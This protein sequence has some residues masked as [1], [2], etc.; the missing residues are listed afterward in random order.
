VI[1]KINMGRLV[2]DILCVNHREFEG[3]LWLSGIEIMRVLASHSEDPM[4]YDVMSAG[5]H[6]TYRWNVGDLAQMAALQQRVK[7]LEA[8]LQAAKKSD[9]GGCRRGCGDF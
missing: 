6:I 8:Q 1:D 4:K 7:E 3:V 5:G 2:A 9:N